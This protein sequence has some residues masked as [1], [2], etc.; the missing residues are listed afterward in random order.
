MSREN[1]L[2]HLHPVFR[3]RLLA[4]IDRFQQENLPFQLFEGYRTPQRQ[5]RLYAQGRSAPGSIVTNAKPWQ[6]FHQYGV[7]GDFV[8]NINGDWSW[9]T[10][11]K[12]GA[13]WSR[14]HELGEQVD[15]KPLSW[16]LPHLQ[17]KD[18]T[19][20]DL[21]MGKYP[22]G[23][24]ESWAAN[25]TENIDMWHGVP[26]APPQPSIIPGRPEL[27][28]DALG[29]AEL[30]EI[31]V[32]RPERAQAYRV[33]ARSGLQLR[34]GPGTEF[35]VVKVLHVGQQVY[36]TSRRENWCQ[37]DVEGDGLADGYCYADYLTPVA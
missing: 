19:L 28:S 9:E 5:A 15:L 23:G 12:K 1:S 13:W 10:S 30:L 36:V 27:P 25:L 17:L 32:S 26:V 33:I 24:D 21:R 6:S 14:L 35:D 20:N 37:V 31:P 29:E 16:E 2:E 22:Q 4:L 8:L 11:G 34:E 7:A 18:L 3:E